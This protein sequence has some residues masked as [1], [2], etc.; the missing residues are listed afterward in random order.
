MNKDYQ[1]EQLRKMLMDSELKSGLYLI[2]TELNDSDIGIVVDSVSSCKYV[3][4]ALMSSQQGST[5]GMF[6]TGLSQY[7]DTEEIREM[8]KYLIAPGGQQNDTILYNLLICTIR[9]LCSELTTI[10]HVCGDLDLKDL[11]PEE[12][13]KIDE[14]IKHFN[15]IVVVACRN[16]SVLTYPI[17]PRINYVKLSDEMTI[18]RVDT[19]I[20]DELFPSRKVRPVRTDAYFDHIADKI[21]NDLDHARVSIHVCMAWF[22]NQRIADKLIEK[23]KGGVDV[24]VISFD[25]HTNAKFGVNIESIPHKMISGTRGGTMH[26]KFCVIDNQKVITGS[27][28]WSVNAENKNDENAAVMYDDERASDYSVEFRNLFGMV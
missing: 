11:Q 28:N 21:I 3:R 7:C 24:K 4:E 19:Q 2:D 27:Y 13:D 5:F 10:I 6:V 14:A 9:H 22:T 17:N 12:I 8:R 20:K 15:R 18:P 16:K 1:L 25:D 26:N 23:F